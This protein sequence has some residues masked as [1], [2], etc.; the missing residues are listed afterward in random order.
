MSEHAHSTPK[1]YVKIWAILVVLLFVSII[2]PEFGIRSV[3]LFTAFG[4][5]FIKAGLVVRKFMHIGD[6][7]PFISYIM[8]TCL[9][10]MLLFFAG[11]APDVMKDSGDN[12]VKP[13][14]TWQYTP[15]PAHHDSNGSD[16][17]ESDD[18]D[19][20]AH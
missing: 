11:T 17:H 1:D 19:A 3:T 6:S 7:P 14:A 8:V 18:T 13:A 2:G 16:G 15:E 9:V 10:F 20:A 4:I 12:W 5:A